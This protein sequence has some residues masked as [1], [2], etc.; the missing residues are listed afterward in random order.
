MNRWWICLGL[1][2]LACSKPKPEGGATQAASAAS[3]NAPALTKSEPDTQVARDQPATEA[4]YEDEAESK[5]TA[6][7]LEA[8][9]DQLE[10]ELKND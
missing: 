8:E 6:Q 4:D 3:A 9:L 7:N 10:K 1:L 5:I 2:L